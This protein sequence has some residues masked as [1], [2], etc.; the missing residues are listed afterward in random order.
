M[1]NANVTAFGNDGS[2]QLGHQITTPVVI[3]SKE[4]K[5]RCVLHGRIHENIGYTLFFELLGEP[6]CLL[7]KSQTYNHTIGIDLQDP[8]IDLPAG[9]DIK[10][11][12][13]MYQTFDT[14]IFI[15]LECMLNAGMDTFPILTR[16]YIGGGNNHLVFTF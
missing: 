10:F 14:D 7:F 9:I 5:G 3:G 15:F 2:N 8:V 16:R 11:V 6:K 12:I 1:R 4:C 13:S